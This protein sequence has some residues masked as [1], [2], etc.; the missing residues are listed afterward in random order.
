V[1]EETPRAAGIVLAGGEG[2]RYGQAKATVVDPDGTSWLR[3]ACDSLLDAAC[4][5]V[6]AVLG[7]DGDGAACHVRDLEAV[8]T[9]VAEGWG[10]GVGASL[11][12]GLATMTGQAPREVTAVVVTLVDLPDV[13]AQV[14]ARLLSTA[15]TAPDVLAR[16]TYDGGPG[17]PVVIGRNH[18]SRLVVT[19]A[20]DRGAAAYL[21]S[22]GALSVECGDLATGRDVDVR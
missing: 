16:A 10:E 17:H 4:N 5:P 8:H 12:F 18:W 9:V 21:S 7:A 3:R 1:P 13:G 15:G 11:R 19:L 20:G 22:H 2:R 6:L 14:V